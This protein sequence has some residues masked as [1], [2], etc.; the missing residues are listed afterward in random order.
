[1]T[2]LLVAVLLI[3]LIIIGALI[4]RLQR[5]KKKL[6]HMKKRRSAIVGEEKRVFQFLQHLGDH[7]RS[8]SS[9]KELHKAIVDGAIEVLMAKE[10][11]LYLVGED[12]DRLVPKYLSKGCPPLYP[13]DDNAT[14]T[15]TATG[16]VSRPKSLMSYLRLQS[17]PAD[18]GVLG[19]CFEKRKV[20]H[21]KNL[22][23]HES[24]EGKFDVV[25][26]KQEAEV[27]IAP[28]IYGNEP[29]GALV[30]AVPDERSTFMN[31]DTLV[32]QSLAEQSAQTLANAMIHR[33]ASQKRQL[34][35]E[36]RTAREVQ[37]VLLPRNNP[38][39]EDYVIAATN[40]P[41]R[42][43]GG[44]YYDFIKVDEDRCGVVIADVSGKGVPA[45]LLMAMAR[46]VLRSHA[47]GVRYPAEVMRT[48][49][50]S[51]FPDMRE[52]MF[53]TMAYLVLDRT[54][55]DIAMA[56]A[57]HDPPLVYRKAT[58]EVEDISVPGIAVGLD[59]G[60]AFDRVTRD[61]TLS[62]DSGDVVIL[63]TDG[64]T[65][66]VNAEGEEFGV[67]RFTALVKEHAPS[68]AQALVDAT[69]STVEKFSGGL[70]QADDITLVV[71][72]KK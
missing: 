54:R 56:R 18:C 44:D 55:N 49:N 64:V 45:S 32:F 40:K 5:T 62:V 53:I 10:G 17:V 43:V 19:E 14:P 52:D 28:M 51:L 68:G 20:V 60:R 63:Y 23:D 71:I 67:E 65:E 39:L 8:G 34:E 37:R 25:F 2:E 30:V 9:T 13:I 29:L 31:N 35:R 59:A 22:F 38:T 6:S 4:Y 46:S 1:M 7:L 26:G 47:R 48:V 15:G 27:L 50:H 12:K 58:G 61:H 11:A 66:A 42:M 41:A 57:G 21:V 24:W 3:L 70:Q 36:I 33:E 72:A 69:D 16:S